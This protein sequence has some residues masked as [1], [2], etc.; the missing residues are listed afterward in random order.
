[1]MRRLLHYLNLE[2]ELEDYDLIHKAIEDDIVFKGTNLWIL[3][4]AILVASVGLNMNSPAVIIGAMLISPLMGPING[5]G[6]SI[7]TYNIPLFRR[8]LK[9]FIFA[10]VASLAASTAY[11][12]ISPVSTAHSELLARTS[13]T[14]YDVL[15]ALFGGLAGIVAISCKRKGNV[16]PGVAIATAL[17]PP[18]CTAGYGLAT[19]QFSFFFGAGYLFLINTVFIALSSVLFSQIFKFPIKTIIDTDQK[20]KINRYISVVIVVMLVPSVYFGYR[21]VQKESFIEKSNRYIASIRLVEGNYLIKSEIFPEKKS[22][23][24][25]YTGK[26][27]SEKT[28]EFIMSQLQNFSITGAQLIIDDAV[29][30]TETFRQNNENLVLKGRV[31]ELTKLLA[32]KADSAKH[33]K[34][35]GYEILAEVSELFPQVK[36]CILTNSYIHSVQD[37]KI[38]ET[39]LVV[40]TVSES[41]PEA[42]KIKIE[43][44]LKIRL[45][46]PDLK[47]IFELGGQ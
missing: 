42:T 18:L 47:V 19:A 27:L 13:P 41:V 38:K 9:N 5:M 15:I 37:I 29:P 1:M 46:T 6:Y 33:F 40:L 7:A 32:E 28:K 8:A 20:V 10:V 26:S 36:A 14:I 17:M 43:N 21:L 35:I 23:H 31:D 12:A 34:T 25:V 39:K 11:F 3:V 16:I 30:M 24:L 44:W 45:K 22:I 4:F 2:N